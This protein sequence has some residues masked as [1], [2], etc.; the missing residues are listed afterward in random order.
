MGAGFVRRL[1]ANGHTVRAWN[2]DGAKAQA[3]ARHGAVACAW[4]A[5]ALAGAERIH[6]ALSDDA[7]VDAVLEPLAGA[8]APNVWIVDHTT[9]AVTPTAE[10]SARWTGRGRV[11]L[12][13]PVF[14]G[15][16][17]AQDGTGVMLLS[18]DKA[19][20]DALLP[21]LSTMTG[22]VAWLGEAPQR[23]AAFKLFGNL[24]LIALTG[25]F[26][27]VARLAHAV[28]I[29]P[30]EAMKLFDLFNPG[31]TLPAR[32]AKV[33]SGSYSPPSFEIAMARKDLR[34]M[35]EEA[36]R[37]GA[38]LQVIPAVAA[39]YDAAIARGAGALDSSAAGAYPPVRPA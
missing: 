4:P 34:L 20:C 24:T 9:T 19:R 10:R 35:M 1:L 39:L 7:A 5:D 15:P 14:M 8:V 32:A 18:G 16:A 30:A 23:A 38:E 27:D 13:A 21:H 11:F 12:H 17:N 25:V 29:E 26:G 33:A 3:L 31:A 36:A 2:R 6:V 28:G 37:G 22:K